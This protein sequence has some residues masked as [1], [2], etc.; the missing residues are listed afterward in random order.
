MTIHITRIVMSAA[1]HTIHCDKLL[2][3]AQ[4][5]MSKDGA[6][7]LRLLLTDATTETQI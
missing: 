6:R 7:I 5:V 4:E 3:I 1:F 2:E